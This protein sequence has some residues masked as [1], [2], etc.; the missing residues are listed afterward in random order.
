MSRFGPP[1]PKPKAKPAITVP[2]VKTTPSNIQNTA[3]QFDYHKHDLFQFQKALQHHE[4]QLGKNPHRVN[5]KKNLSSQ[6]LHPFTREEPPIKPQKDYKRNPQ[7][8]YATL[9][10][11]IRQISEQVTLSRSPERYERLQNHISSKFTPEAEERKRLAE[12]N[13]TSKIETLK[14]V[15]KEIL[16][17][18]NEKQS[19]RQGIKTSYVNRNGHHFVNEMPPEK[20]HK[21][22]SF[23]NVP[24]GNRSDFRPLF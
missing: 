6:I 20:P 8:L 4:E 23:E 21:V 18:R 17:M 19:A 7:Q 9:R 10:D 24:C 16:D 13:Q 12:F 1:P 3:R 2:K 14:A 11:E 5:I 15:K 22:L